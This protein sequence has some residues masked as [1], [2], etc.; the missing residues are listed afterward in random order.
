M[1]SSGRLPMEESFIRG[2]DPVCVLLYII[3]S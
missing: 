1:A 2:N 3:R